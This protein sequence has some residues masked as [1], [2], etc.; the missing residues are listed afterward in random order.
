MLPIY[1][2]RPYFYLS[3]FYQTL[4]KKYRRLHILCRE[5]KFFVID[6][7]KRKIHKR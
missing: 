3:M 6:L 2:R 5:V 1:D 4:K 7:P